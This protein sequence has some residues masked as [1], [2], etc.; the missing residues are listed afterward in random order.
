MGTAAFDLTYVVGSL[1]DIYF[2]YG[3]ARSKA[4]VLVMD[5]FFRFV[6]WVLRVHFAASPQ[7][8]GTG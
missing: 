6:A 8:H 1:A 2:K 3:T 4:P 7:P 5:I